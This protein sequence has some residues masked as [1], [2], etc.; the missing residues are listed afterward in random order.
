MDGQDGCA[1]DDGDRAGLCP[2]PGQ[3]SP[4]Q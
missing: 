4:P 3:Q 2:S 1:F